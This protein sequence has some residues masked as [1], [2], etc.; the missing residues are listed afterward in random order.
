MRGL[1]VPFAEAKRAQEHFGVAFAQLVDPRET[2]E[3]PGP[4]PG[5]KRHVAREL[6]AHVVEQRLEEMFASSTPS[7]CGRAS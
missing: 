1:S 3:L 6:I 7:C 5:Q 4:G 2:V